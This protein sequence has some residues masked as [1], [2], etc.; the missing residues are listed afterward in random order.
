MNVKKGKHIITTEA[1][2]LHRLAK[3]LDENFDLAI[4]SIL[5][6]RG[7]VLL[8]GVGKSG[9]IARKIASTLTS[10]GTKS[11][12]IHPTEASH[13]DLGVINN[14]DLILALSNSGESKELNDILNYCKRF[15]IFIIGITSIINSSLA[16]AS[17]ITLSIPK[18]NDIGMAGLAPTSTT[19]MML[20]LGDAIAITLLENRGF[21]EKDFKKLHPGGKIGAQLLKIKDIMHVGKA[22]PIVNQQEIMKSVFIEITKKS[23]GCVGVVDE[24]HH[25][26]GVITDG[27]LRR[28][29]SDSILKDIAKDIMTKDPKTI[30]EDAL[31]SEALSILNNHKI[32]ALFVSSND[33]NKKPVGIIHLHDCLRLGAL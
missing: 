3:E 19:T 31:V 17:N 21:S 13:G 26:V 22:M 1:E 15:K 7:N 30:R 28:N 29:M 33:N 25:L 10:T 12:F 27:D 8:T 11:L 5:S 9:H 23:F 32:T 6:L 24:N 16:K 20:A 2:S 14:N 4:K 18:T